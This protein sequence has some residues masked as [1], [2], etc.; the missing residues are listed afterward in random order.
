[1]S[2]VILPGKGNN[3]MSN[4]L[5]NICFECAEKIGM[6]DMFW[7]QGGWGAEKCFFCKKRKPCI[8][9][10]QDNVQAKMQVAN[11]KAKAGTDGS[12]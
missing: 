9:V 12:L 1:M 3:G 4:K 7:V 2:M 8:K 5:I 10:Y 6:E 11:K